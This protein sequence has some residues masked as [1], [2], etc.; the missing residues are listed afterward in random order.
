MQLVDEDIEFVE[1]NRECSYFND[2]ISDIRYRYLQQCSTTDYQNMLEHG[3]RRFGK[4]HFVPECANCTKC[5]SMRIDVKNYH[6]SKSEK[7]VLAKNRDTKIYIQPPSLTKDHLLLYDKYHKNMHEKKG[8]VYSPIEPIEYNR[9]YVQ[10][11]AEYAKEFL[12]VKDG[13]LI[14]VALTDI[15]P[16]SISSIYCF[17][18]HDYD[19][20]SIGKFSI[21]AQIKVAK[22][23]NIP[24]IYLGYWIEN[25]HSMGY[26]LAY[27]P[28]EILKNRAS[29][30]EPTIWEKYEDNEL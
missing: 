9:S 16:K 14:G 13:K 24:Y 25:H 7:R 19:H 18:D 6:F 2:E 4:M 3:W 20:L 12:Y 8:W 17:Y 23:L 10:G 22:E 15:L 21:L 5:I 11:K 27:K 26:K 28:F 30:E 1:Q 29:L